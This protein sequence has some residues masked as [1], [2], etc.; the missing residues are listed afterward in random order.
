MLSIKLLCIYQGT[1]TSQY[2]VI[3]PHVYLTKS[4]L[5]AI[6]SYNAL[7]SSNLT[8]FHSLMTPSLKWANVGKYYL[9]NLAYT[10][11]HIFSIKLKSGEFGGHSNN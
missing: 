7:T 6:D 1:M 5:C 2:F 3:S 10:K 4:S 11:P 9:S 8:E